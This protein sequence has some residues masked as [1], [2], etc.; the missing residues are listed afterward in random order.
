VAR[1]FLPARGASTSS[2]LVSATGQK[3]SPASFVLAG[4][5][6]AYHVG[7]Q[8]I[9]IRDAKPLCLKL[10]TLRV[11]AAKFRFAG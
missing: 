11:L 2:R 7:G 4:G 8:G 1:D 9:S 6:V 5:V 3:K 10:K